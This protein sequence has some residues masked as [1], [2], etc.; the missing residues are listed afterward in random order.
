MEDAFNGASN[1]EYRATDTPDLSNVSKMDFVTCSDGA[2]SFNWDI[3]DWDVSKV[4]HMTNMFQ[5]ATSFNQPLNDWKTS[6]K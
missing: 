1:M 5:G 3:S 6:R 2:S 4:T